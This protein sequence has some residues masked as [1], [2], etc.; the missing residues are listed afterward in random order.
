MERWTC[1]GNELT[2]RVVANIV[3][4]AIR[5]RPCYDAAVYLLYT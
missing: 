2:D 3:Q 1:G 5:I 4:S